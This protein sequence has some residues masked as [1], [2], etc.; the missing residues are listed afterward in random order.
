MP[1]NPLYDY[2]ENLQKKKKKAFSGTNTSLL[3]VCPVSFFLLLLPCSTSE[4]KFF[5]RDS[6]FKDCSMWLP[7]IESVV[8]FLEIL[9]IPYILS[10]YTAH[11]FWGRSS[12]KNAQPARGFGAQRGR[13]DVCIYMG[14]G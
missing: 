6:T 2:F 14:S 8:T 1:H 3:F 9:P 4:S 5:I 12:V 11:S 7:K 13:M 10:R